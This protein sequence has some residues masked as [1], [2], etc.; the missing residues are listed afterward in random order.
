MRE[1]KFRV[2]DK[3]E[4]KMIYLD[5]ENIGIQIY[6]SGKFEP[7]SK[8]RGYGECGT[9]KFPNEYILMQYIGRK[10]INGKKIFEGDITN[11]GIVEYNTKLNWDGGGSEHP[12]FYFREG[13]DSLGNEAELEYHTGFDDCKVLGNIFENPELLEEK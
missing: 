2:W 10:D 7:Y 8:D 11:H 5:D 6:L 3:E 1:I 9:Y 13:Y 12:G 4:N